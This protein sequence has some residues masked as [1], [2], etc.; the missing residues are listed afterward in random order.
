MIEISQLIRTSSTGTQIDD[1]VARPVPLN[2]LPHELEEGEVNE[3]LR[4]DVDENEEAV[5]KEGMGGGRRR[6]KKRRNNKKRRSTKKRRQNK[7]RR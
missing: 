5:N 4:M 3:I 1:D 2:L 6:S 7:R